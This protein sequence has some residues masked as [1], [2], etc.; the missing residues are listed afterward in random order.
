M[1]EKILNPTIFI[2]MFQLMVLLFSLCLLKPIEAADLP[3]PPFKKLW[4]CRVGEQ[5]Y[6]P[7]FCDSVICFDTW[8]SFKAIV[9]GAVDLKTGKILWKKS[10]KGFHIIEKTYEKKRLYMVVEKTGTDIEKNLTYTGCG[11]V[12]VFN[13][14]SGD[15][16]LR[17]PVDEVECSPA[18]KNATLYC[19][20]RDNVLKSIDLDTHKTIWV[21]T[22]PDVSDNVKIL[23]S[24]TVNRKQLEVIGVYLF[25]FDNNEIV[26]VNR[27]T[28][29]VRW[30]YENA[31]GSIAADDKGKHIYINIERELSSLNGINGTREWTVSMESD[32]LRPPVLYRGLIFIVC[33]DG[34]LYAL[35][36][37]SGK[38]SWK[39]HLSKG[40][41]ARFSTLVIQKNTIIVS[42]DSKL[43]ALDLS[44]KILWE[45][46]LR[47]FPLD[48]SIR[49][50]VV[51]EDGYLLSSFC[52]IFKIV[53]KK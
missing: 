46:E 7:T 34:M 50:I 31:Y 45:F 10:I 18:I 24:K 25:I 27:Q 47:D 22:I 41:F 35:E 36:A 30:R 33:R 32:I 14:D 43:F 42:A 39:C 48:S 15:E 53:T 9:F 52:S 21:T 12:I 37:N 16:L 1:S 29:E 17:I 23:S 40:E 49:D 28:G 20:F 2:K 11:E 26:C 3:A 19:I 6:H 38:V 4:A 8:P 5:V 51:L 44:G 13:P